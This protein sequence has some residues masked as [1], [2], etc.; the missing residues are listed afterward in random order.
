[1]ETEDI[2]QYTT[3]R[4]AT[5]SHKKS[6]MTSDPFLTFVATTVGCE[7]VTRMNRIQGLWS[8]YGEV[9]RL[10]VNGR[11]KDDNPQTIVVKRVAPPSQDGEDIGHER[12]LRSYEVESNFY[13]FFSAN[14]EV[15]YQSHTTMSTSSDKQHQHHMLSRLFLPVLVCLVFLAPRNMKTNIG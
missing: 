2:S 4:P 10:A 9:V 13:R 7:S 3:T 14:L 15:P 8:G 11:G 1:M 6:T 5:S 12:K